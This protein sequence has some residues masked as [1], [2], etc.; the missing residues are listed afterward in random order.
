[1]D[2]KKLEQDME[3]WEQ[4]DEEVVGQMFAR[5]DGLRIHPPGGTLFENLDFI[6]HVDAVSEIID[7]SDSSRQI[8]LEAWLLIDYIV[9]YFL[10]DALRIPER[11]EREL[12]LLPHSFVNKIKLIKKLRSVEARKLPNQKSYTA[13]ELHPEFHKKLM[14]D[15]EFHRKFL[16]LAVQFEEETAPSE[17][18]A[19]MRNDFELARFVPEWWYELAAQLDDDWFR[20]CERLNRA[21][22]MAA[23]S[24]RLNNDDVFKEFDVP[25][26]AELK[27]TMRGII[28]SLVFRRA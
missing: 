13:Y 21:R 9:T 5:M 28:D 24:L 20:D 11:I 3:K 26:L 1:M 10:R 17:L 8:I 19:I 6:E 25:S 14:E 18:R 27:K 12:R 7:A 2:F 23:H 22:N 4:V 15:K 16:M